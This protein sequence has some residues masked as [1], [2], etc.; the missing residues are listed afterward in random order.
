VIINVCVCVVCVCE[1]VCV[2]VEG[3]V[4]QLVT[5]NVQVEN[6]WPLVPSDYIRGLLLQNFSDAVVT[7]VSKS[8]V[9]INN[10]VLLPA[11][12]RL[13][14]LPLVQVACVLGGHGNKEYKLFICAL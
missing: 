4:I 11:S 1:C 8:L 2:S 7:S 12:G 10:C 3:P 5:R 14:E 6:D 13:Q 9:G